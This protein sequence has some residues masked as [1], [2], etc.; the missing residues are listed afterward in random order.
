MNEYVEK[1]CLKADSKPQ[2]P[3]D[4]IVKDP[5]PFIRSPK[6]RPAARFCARQQRLQLSSGTAHQATDD[7]GP[8]DPGSVVL[9]LDYLV[10]SPSIFVDHEMSGKSAGESHLSTPPSISDSLPPDA[11]TRHFDWALQVLN[12]NAVDHANHGPA[13]VE[14]CIRLPT[15]TLLSPPPGIIHLRSPPSFIRRSTPHLRSKGGHSA[16]TTSTSRTA[17]A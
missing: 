1:G 15:P 6:N 11:V 4:N 10:P 12:K 14:A 2:V 16:R 9:N 17:A 7:Q 5:R 13:M 8:S 3:D